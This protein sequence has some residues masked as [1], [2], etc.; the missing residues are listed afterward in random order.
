MRGGSR[1]GWIASSGPRPAPSER[2]S[3]NNVVPLLPLSRTVRIPDHLFLIESIVD[4]E[5]KR[6]VAEANKLISD[7][8]RAAIREQHAE[9]SENFLKSIAETLFEDEQGMITGIVFPTAP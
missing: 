1:R 2:P 4:E 8:V 9:A 3:M 7:H 5:A 6:A